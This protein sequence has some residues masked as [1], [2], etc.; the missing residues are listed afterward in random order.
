VPLRLQLQSSVHVVAVAVG[1]AAD[2]AVITR[3]GGEEPQKPAARSRI[4]ASCAACRR[5]IYEG[6]KVPEG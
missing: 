5:Y 6:F 2:R 1:A 4:H 3:V